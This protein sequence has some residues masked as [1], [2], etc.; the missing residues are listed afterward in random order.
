MIGNIAI[1]F[2][3]YLIVDLV[4]SCR[5]EPIYI[6]LE[7]GMGGEEMMIFPYDAQVGMFINFLDIYRWPADR[8]CTYNSCFSFKWKIQFIRWCSL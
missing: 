2:I 8:C 6:P 4:I 5:P 1:C 7:E 3:I